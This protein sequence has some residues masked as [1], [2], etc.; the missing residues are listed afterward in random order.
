VNSRRYLVRET[1]EVDAVYHVGLFDSYSEAQAFIDQFA[2]GPEAPE[3]CWTREIVDV[4]FLIP[5]FT[6]VES[7]GKEAA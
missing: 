7:I 1:T 5:G 3:G 2:T 4:E 6:P